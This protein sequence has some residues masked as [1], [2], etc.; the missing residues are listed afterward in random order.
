MT[1]H[2]DNLYEKRLRLE[3]FKN[4]DEAVE[5]INKA[6]EQMLKDGATKVEMELDANRKF[7]TLRGLKYV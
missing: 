6:M 3:C 7:V 2:P 1:G 4:L 5:W